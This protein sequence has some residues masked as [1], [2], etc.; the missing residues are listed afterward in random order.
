[1]TL[2]RRVS[3][4][5]GVLLGLAGLSGCNGLISD[6]GV[7]PGG[8]DTPRVPTAPTVC[9]DDTIVLGT[10]PMRRLSNVEYQSG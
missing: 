4:L 5:S 3:F 8:G 6:P 10:A 9:T 1:M 2:L 7:G